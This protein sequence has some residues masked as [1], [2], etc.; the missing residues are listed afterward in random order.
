MTKLY[1]CKFA[2]WACSDLRDE[3]EAKYCEPKPSTFCELN[4]ETD[5]YCDLENASYGTRFCI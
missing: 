5:E 3:L 4:W 1:C 2:N